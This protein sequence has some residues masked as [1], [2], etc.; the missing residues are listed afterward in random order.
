MKKFYLDGIM[1]K[2]YIVQLPTDDPA[3]I[4]N[5]QIRFEKTIADDYPFLML[6]QEVIVT[7]VK[8]G[9][10]LK[11]YKKPKASLKHRLKLNYRRIKKWKRN[12]KR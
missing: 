2:K 12:L 3:V 9:G 11:R 8:R 6:P 4:K 1:D 10:K 7:E 5:F